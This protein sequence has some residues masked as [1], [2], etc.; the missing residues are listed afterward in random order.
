MERGGGRFARSPRPSSS[1]NHLGWSGAATA[2][3]ARAVQ[4]LYLQ[5]SRHGTS[6]PD[7]GE[8]QVIRARG[9]LY[10]KHN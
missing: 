5:G 8:L 4:C 1:N 6:V 2:T 9:H 10:D 3:A 7:K